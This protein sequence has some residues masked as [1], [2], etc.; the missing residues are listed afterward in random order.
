MKSGI[1][2]E[3]CGEKVRCG[4]GGCG[5]GCGGGLDMVAVL[6]TRDGMKG[7]LLALIW[8]VDWGLGESWGVVWGGGM[9]GN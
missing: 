5:C 1:L 9:V 7:G 3:G 6:D 4:C 2:R 8:W